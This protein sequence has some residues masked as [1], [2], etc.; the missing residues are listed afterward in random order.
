MLLAVGAV[1]TETA[2]VTLAQIIFTSYI[3]YIGT[4]TNASAVGDA[5]CHSMDGGEDS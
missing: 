4:P 2:I 1:V 3:A 5:G